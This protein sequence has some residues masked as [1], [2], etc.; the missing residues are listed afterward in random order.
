[1]II[2]IMI[3]INLSLSNFYLNYQY[4]YFFFAFASLLSR[5]RNLGLSSKPFLIPF[6]KPRSITN[7]FMQAPYFPKLCR[8]IS[9][10]ISMQALGHLAI[11]YIY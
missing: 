3:L 10:V 9:D 5:L 1:M 8:L 7:N 11:I 2:E 4:Y 6:N